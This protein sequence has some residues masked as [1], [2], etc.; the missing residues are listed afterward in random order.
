LVGQ[1][2]I[3]KFEPSVLIENVHPKNDSEMTK[4][5][6]TIDLLIVPSNQD[7][8]PSVIGEALAV[9][10]SVIGSNAGGIPEILKDFDMPIFS[11]GDANQLAVLI[12]SYH[13]APSREDIREKAKKYFSEEIQGRKLL[14]IYGN[15][16]Q[17]LSKR[18]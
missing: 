4:L 12:D 6:S 9:G 17:K 18:N 14:E 16:H 8:S 10:V 13:E 3:P 15:L 5:L 2:N 1:G 11:V 7:N